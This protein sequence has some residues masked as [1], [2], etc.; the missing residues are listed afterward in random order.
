MSAPLATSLLETRRGQMFPRFGREQIEVIRRFAGPVQR[1]AP[2]QLLVKVGERGSPSCLVLAGSIV[3]NWR[4]GLGGTGNIT[5]HSVGQFTGEIGA[6][7]GRPSMAELTAGPEG[8]EVAPLDAA[9]LRAVVVGNAE[10]GEIVMRALILRRVGLIQT[11]AG[12]PILLGRAGSRDLVRLQ[13]F[14]SSNGIPNTTLDP[15]TD[16]DAEILIDRFRVAPEQLPLA[17]C[18]GGQVLRNPIEAEL[19][20]CLG[21]VPELRLDRPYDVAIVGAG[22][23]G[24]ATAVYAA[25]EGLSVIVLDSRAFGGQAGASARIENYLGFPTGISGQ[26]LAGRAF[27]QAQKFGAEI[28]IPVE[29]LRL[30]CGGVKERSDD[31]PPPDCRQP[32]FSLCL[33]GSNKRVAARAVVIA[34]GARY[35]RPEIDKLQEF[36]GRGIY[37]WASPVEARLCGSQEVILVGGGNSAGQAAVFLS[38]HTARVHLLVRRRGL[39][40]T[41]SRYLIDRIAGLGNVELHPETEIVRL[42]GNGAGLECVHWKNRRTSVVER[43][44]IRYV[45]LFAGAVPNARWLDDTGVTLDAKGFVKTGIQLRQDELDAAGWNS[46]APAPLPLETSRAGVFAIGDVRA[47]SVK[48]VAS[49]VG[50]GAAV[51]A[52]LHQFLTN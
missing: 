6:L 7:S 50:E 17:V 36:E 16:H 43:R 12:G 13:S 8:C 42:T 37:Y 35:R 10:I 46:R 52:Q 44:E 2:G 41:M 48:R 4:D 14:L 19:A 49:A 26:A 1:F 33:T 45:F 15:D 23:A 32:S 20:Q 38:G 30:Q 34:S 27:T 11:G 28:A 31:L 47:G 18:P 39:E 40:E 25:S 3:V 21:L 22:P 29:V 51:V 5:T 9:A 24:L